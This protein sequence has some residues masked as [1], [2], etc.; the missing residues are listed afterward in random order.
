VR[1]ARAE[2][3][4]IF[5]GDHVY[6]MD[7]EQMEAMHREQQA[8]LTVAAFPVPTSEASAF[9]IIDVDASG[10]IVGCIEQPKNPPEI[11]GRPGWSL[12]WRGK[13]ICRRDV[14]ER[15]LGD[16][17]AKRSSRHDF[18]RD[19]IPGLVAAGARVFAYD[20]AK[21]HIPGEPEGEPYWRDVGT[22]E[23]YFA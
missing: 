3:I 1:D 11:P 2:H 23:S 18:G 8:D 13:Y 19:I 4:C 12:V 22:I 5:G 20:F 16:E 10:R 9:G 17:G 7:V 6:K 21:N 14:L 15:V